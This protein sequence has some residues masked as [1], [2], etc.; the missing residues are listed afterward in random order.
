MD[1]GDGRQTLVIEKAG[2]ILLT[3]AK[4][5]HAK[6][7]VGCFNG[8]AFVGRRVFEVHAGDARGDVD[9]SLPL[10]DLDVSIEWDMRMGSHARVKQVRPT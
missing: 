8:D 3:I 2:L 4:R 5:P 7:R 10:A 1:R 9:F 6:W